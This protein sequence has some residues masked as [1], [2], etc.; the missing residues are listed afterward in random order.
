MRTFTVNRFSIQLGLLALLSVAGL[1][2]C[3]EKAAEAAKPAGAAPGGDPAAPADK[4]ADKP[5]AGEGAYKQENTADNLKGLLQAIGAAAKAGDSASAGGLTRALLLDDAAIKVAL[6]DDAP[7][8]LMAG[9]KE[10]LAK[11][12]PDNAMLAKMLVPP[13]ERTEVTAHAATTEQI[14]ANAP[15]TAAA[16]EFP[17]GARKLAEV[18]LK[19]GLTFYEVEFTEPGKDSGMK[20]H[21][22]FWDG[23]AW[24]MLGAA[25]RGLRAPAEAAPK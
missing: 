8:E 15:G 6:R 5:T 4:P 18:A 16:N 10:Q 9:L 23:K 12:P 14:L 13:P 7:A 25:W 11:V 21:L 19:P 22:F 17:G 3:K 1:P 20:Y 2:G 24:K